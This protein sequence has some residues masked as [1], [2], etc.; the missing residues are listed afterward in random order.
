MVSVFGKQLHDQKHSHLKNFYVIVPP[1]TV[2]FV[3]HMINAKERMNKNN[4]S[5]GAAFTDDGLAMGML[6][7]LQS[8]KIENAGPITMR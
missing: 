6:F 2:N 8:D 1:L 5:G 4:I 3:E 7:L